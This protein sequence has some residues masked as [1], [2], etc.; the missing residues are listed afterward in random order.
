M[1]DGHR[2]DGDVLIYGCLYTDVWWY[3]MML[4][5]T[6]IYVFYDLCSLYFIFVTVAIKHE[7]KMVELDNS[8]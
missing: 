6:L 4:Y 5:E 3:Y 2:G 7:C 1:R 8:N